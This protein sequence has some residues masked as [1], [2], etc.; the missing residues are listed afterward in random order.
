ME[1]WIP[2]SFEE[3]EK[4]LEDLDKKVIKIQSKLAGKYK[5]GKNRNISKAARNL[6]RKEENKG[7]RFISLEK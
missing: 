3:A 1:I 2:N 5:I 4:R 6:I 7:I